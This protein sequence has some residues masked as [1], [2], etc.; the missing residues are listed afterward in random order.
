MRDREE[1]QGGQAQRFA[2]LFS[3]PRS[4]AGFLAAAS[5]VVLCVGCA[6]CEQGV[7]SFLFSILR[8]FV[9]CVSNTIVCSSIQQQ[10]QLC[11]A[12]TA[13]SFAF[14]IAWTL[15]AK[16]KYVRGLIVRR[17]VRGHTLR[18]CLSSSCAALFVAL[19]SSAQARMNEAP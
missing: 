1:S 4:V 10:L 15:P 14:S 17:S 18:S 7:S 8:S 2:P 11:Q 13:L 9:Q 19:C 12:A 5:F 6:A 16:P 3:S